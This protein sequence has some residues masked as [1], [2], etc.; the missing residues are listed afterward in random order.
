MYDQNYKKIILWFREI[1]IE[2]VFL[3]RLHTENKW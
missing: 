1:A 3:Y 2:I